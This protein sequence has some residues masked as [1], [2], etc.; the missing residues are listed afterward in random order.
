MSPAHA[1]IINRVL[2]PSQEDVG[3]ARRI[4]AAFESARERGEDRVDVDGSL[5]EVPTYMN[6]KRLIARAEALARAET[7]GGNPP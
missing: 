6:A 1:A 4:V 2:T 5:V 3:K 7:P